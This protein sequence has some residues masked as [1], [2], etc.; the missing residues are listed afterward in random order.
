MVQQALRLVPP[1]GWREFAAFAGPRLDNLTAWDSVVLVG[2]ASHPL[3]GAFGSGAGF[4]LEDGWILARALEYQLK[5]D[6]LNAVP[7]AL[8]LFDKIRSPYYQQMYEHLD[9]EKAKQLAVRGQLD[10]SWEGLTRAKVKPTGGKGMEWI[11]DNDI[12]AV[13]NAF[14]KSNAKARENTS[15]PADQR[16]FESL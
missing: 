13:W 10:Q 4:A 16:A 7:E 2:D 14:P 3:S 11:Y 5:I 6:S 12:Q 9:G 15:C 8:A 1:G